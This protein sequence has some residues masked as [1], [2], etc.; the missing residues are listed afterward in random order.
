[1]TGQLQ[2]LALLAQ[3]ARFQPNRQ[4]RRNV[5]PSKRLRQDDIRQD[6]RHDLFTRARREDRSI[7]TVAARVTGPPRPIS[8]QV[9]IWLAVAEGKARCSPSP[10]SVVQSRTAN[11]DRSRPL[12]RA[13]RLA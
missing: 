6:Q 8:S 2:V 5:G 13:D 7:S 11:V 1:M 4:K 3:I 10:R 9:A 12:D